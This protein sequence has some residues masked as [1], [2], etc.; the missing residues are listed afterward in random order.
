ML[1]PRAAPEL[2]AANQQELSQVGDKDETIGFPIAGHL[3]GPCNQ[4]DGLCGSLRLDDAAIG[5]QPRTIVVQASAQLAL[6]EQPEIRLPG[7]GPLQLRLAEDLRFEVP[8]DLVEKV[9][10]RRVVGGL[11][12]RKPGRTNGPKL[13][14]ILLQRRRQW[15]PQPI[16]PHVADP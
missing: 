12:G 10:Q 9:G 14:Q 13:G 7:R 11:T 4:L 3:L 16:V 1:E 6:G 2:I 5:R 8:P 15:L